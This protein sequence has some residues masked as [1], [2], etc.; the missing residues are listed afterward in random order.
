MGAG[1]EKDFY[2]EGEERFG[3]FVSR[4]YSMTRMIPTF[5]NFY[6]FV[7]DD[8]KSMD[9]YR[10]LDIGSGNGYL[11]LSLAKHKSNFTGTGIDP[12][13]Y[14]VRVASKNASKYGLSDRI[15]FEMGSSREIPQKES[16]DIIYTS[17]SFHHWKDRESSIPGIMSKLT[18][19][20]SFLIYEVTDN[21]SIAR[22]LM[23]RHTMDSETF[24]AISERM[25]LHMEIKEKEGFIRCLFRNGS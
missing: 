25:N 22:K 14:M 1:S 24:K 8:L 19:K 3:L 13:S 16:Y 6:R 21:G 9:F 23:K 12:S 10:I 11:A 4:M 7:I 20:G 17:M 15:K 18:A 5:R 2:V